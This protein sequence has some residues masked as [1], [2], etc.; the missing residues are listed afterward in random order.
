MATYYQAAFNEATYKQM[1]FNMVSTFSHMVVRDSYKMADLVLTWRLQAL[2]AQATSIVRKNFRLHQLI[3]VS[4]CINPCH[5]KKHFY[6]NDDKNI[7]I[8][9][10][11]GPVELCWTNGKCFMTFVNGRLQTM[12]RRKN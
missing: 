2:G 7:Y 6:N 9:M 8:V 1:T 3:T 4:H 11:A 12:Q 10:K 5:D